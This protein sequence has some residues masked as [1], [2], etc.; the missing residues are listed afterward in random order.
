[1]NTK[2]NTTLCQ[3]LQNKDGCKKKGS[4]CR[5]LPYC[6]RALFP[7]PSYQF[8]TPALSVLEYNM[9]KRQHIRKKWAN[10]FALHGS[11]QTLLDSFSFCLIHEWTQT[12]PLW[13]GHGLWIMG[14]WDAIISISLGQGRSRAPKS[15]T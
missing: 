2:N 13:P 8:P 5:M 9:G 6:P 14:E 7:T 11:F 1:M 3:I 12:W 15:L 4:K 10:T